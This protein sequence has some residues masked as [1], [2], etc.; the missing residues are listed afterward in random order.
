MLESWGL[1][2]PPLSSRLREREIKPA[3]T[4]FAQKRANG[5]KIVELFCPKGSQ[6]DPRAIPNFTCGS[7]TGG[8]I[9]TNQQA[10]LVII[11]L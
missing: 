11:T 6:I 5:I 8:N 9:G 7:L 10:D 3:H 1:L 2:E 4:V